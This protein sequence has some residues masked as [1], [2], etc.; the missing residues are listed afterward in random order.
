MIGIGTQIGTKGGD[1]GGARPKPRRVFPREVRGGD[2]LL[3]G[4]FRLAG[5]ELR[6][7]ERGAARGGAAAAVARDTQR[8]GRWG[9]RE[10]RGRQVPQLEGEAAADGISGDLPC[11]QRRHA[12]HPPPRHVPLRRIHPRR[13]QRHPQAR[14][15]GPLPPHRLRLAAAFPSRHCSHSSLLRLDRLSFFFFLQFD[16]SCFFFDFTSFLGV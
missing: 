5:G 15:E 3:L 8:A 4:A 7:G 11:W 12:G 10:E 16:P 13:G 14:M 9:P 1:R 2:P 6:R